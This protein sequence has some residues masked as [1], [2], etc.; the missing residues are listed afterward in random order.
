VKSFRRSRGEGNELKRWVRGVVAIV[1]FLIPAAAFAQAEKRGAL[2]QMTDAEKGELSEALARYRDLV[3]NNPTIVA[4]EADLKADAARDKFKA[5]MQKEIERDTAVA[6]LRS[7]SSAIADAITLCPLQEYALAECARP[8][9]VGGIS[10]GDDGLTK[11]QRAAR[12]RESCYTSALT[13]EMKAWTPDFLRS[14]VERRPD[15]IKYLY[16]FASRFVYVATPVKLK[17]TG[18]KALMANL[19]D[20]WAG[21]GSTTDMIQ[22]VAVA[23]DDGNAAIECYLLRSWADAGMMGPDWW[24][25]VD[26]QSGNSKFP[27]NRVNHFHF[28]GTSGARAPGDPP[29]THVEMYAPT[30]CLMSLG[31][32]WFEPRPDHSLVNI[33]DWRSLRIGQRVYAIWAMQDGA[34]AAVSD[35][36]LMTKETTGVSEQTH[37]NKI[38][39]YPSRRMIKTSASAPH[40][41]LGGGLF[42][43][44]GFLLGVMD[45]RGATIA[46]RDWQY[47]QCLQSGPYLG[48]ERK[49][50]CEHLA[51]S[52]AKSE[53]AQ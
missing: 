30:R 16:D 39:R 36:F 2:A 34:P 53:G 33:R 45:K 29:P 50:E 46:A 3:K 26:I 14:R 48:G 13:R 35:G 17:Q 12:D 9:R 1:L 49:P 52:D 31:R 44:S 27:N 42:D 38:L 6:E 8:N 32:D 43:S 47:E 20:Y 40:G 28:Q 5:C 15:G 18:V 11:E 4:T 37:G 22:G 21:K 10:F 7:L 25:T 24:W 23:L 51:P 41:T 19:Y